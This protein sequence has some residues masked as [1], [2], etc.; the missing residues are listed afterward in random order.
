MTAPAHR[1]LEAVRSGVS[2]E[3]SDVGGR[4]RPEHRTWHPVDVP[5]VVVGQYLAR[6]LVHDELPIESRDLAGQD[7]WPR[8]ADG[9]PG[10]ATTDADERRHGV[11]QERAPRGEH[12]EAGH[13]CTPLLAEWGRPPV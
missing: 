12:R 13:H 7:G 5:A 2:N 8:G 9:R 11:S 3:A 6:G 10:Q 4:G 1:D